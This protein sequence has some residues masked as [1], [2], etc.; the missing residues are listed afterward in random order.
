MKNLKVLAKVGTAALLAAGSIT[1]LNS[2]AVTEPTIQTVQMQTVHADTNT[3]IKLPAGYTKARVLKVNNNKLSASQKRALIE[4]CKKGMAEN[5]FYGE[6]SDKSRIVDV[7]HLS[8][9]EKE[10]ISKYTLALINS[11]R[12]QMGKRSWTYRKGAVTFA[13]R[14]GQVY[15]DESGLPITSQWRGTQR[16][17]YALKQQIYFNVKQ[18]LFGGFYG[19]K[20]NY[21]DSS[22]YTEWE[23]AGELLGLRSMKGYDAKTKYFA[24]PSLLCLVTMIKLVFT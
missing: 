5:N 6:D 17:M 13:D 18:M 3:S 24:F 16:S 12:S 1:V 7:N 4:A 23:H 20:E 11:A 2:T 21:N 22:R 9:Q 14:A 19:T 8:Y 15:E 10:K